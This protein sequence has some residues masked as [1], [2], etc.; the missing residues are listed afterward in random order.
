MNL[1][2][3]YNCMI[4]SLDT[5]QLVKEAIYIYTYIYMCV[6]FTWYR[7]FNLVNKIMLKNKDFLFYKEFTTQL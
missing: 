1:T 3:Q 7:S 5:Y 6:C 2:I 4:C